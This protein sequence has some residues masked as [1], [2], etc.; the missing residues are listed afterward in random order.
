MGKKITN[1]KLSREDGYLYYLGK[2]GFV[3]K[4]PMRHNKKGRKCKV[5]SE[6]VDRKKGYMYYVKDGYVFE[7]KMKNA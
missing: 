3:W 1:E 7:T 4:S 5:G 2:D 6:R